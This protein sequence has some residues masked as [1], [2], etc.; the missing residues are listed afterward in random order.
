MESTLNP[1]PTAA[2]VKVAVSAP[3]RSCQ[4]LSQVVGEVV[5]ML[6]LEKP[7]ILDRLRPI[8]AVDQSARVPHLSMVHPVNI[9]V[10]HAGLEKL[11]LV[12]GTQRHQDLLLFLQLRI[13]QFQVSLSR[14]T[15]LGCCMSFPFRNSAF[16]LRLICSS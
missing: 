5:V 16:A 1:A 8:L 7:A 10:I 6:T 12:N 15:N 14:S 2:C 3:W 13:V 9:A 11:A 4:V